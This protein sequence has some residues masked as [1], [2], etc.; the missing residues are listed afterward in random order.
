M[1]R[2]AVMQ[3]TTPQDLTVTYGLTAVAAASDHAQSCAE[4]CTSS[5]RLTQM[6]S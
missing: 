2:H 1:F 5:A 6:R 3:V 4:T